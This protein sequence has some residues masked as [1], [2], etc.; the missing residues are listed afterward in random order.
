[1]PVAF[2]VFVKPIALLVAVVQP[3]HME[4]REP[5]T[6]PAPRWDLAEILDGV[7]H[8]VRVR[9]IRLVNDQT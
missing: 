9:P 4:R 1:M 2:Q 8:A 6:R 3:L 5:L 7:L